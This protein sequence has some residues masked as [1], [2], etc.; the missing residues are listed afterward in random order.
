MQ[1]AINVEHLAYTYPGVDDTPGVAVFKD[2]SLQIE[3]GTFVAVLGGN[4]C[5]KSTLAKHFNAILTP[6]SGTVLVTGID[7]KNEDMLFDIRQTVG[8]VF[9]NPD[10]QIIT[11]TVEEELAFGL[12]NLGVPREQ[13]IR[14]I[15][16]IL[17][18]FNIS[19]LMLLFS[20]T[21]T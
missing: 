9:Q 15:N 13:M 5:G 18:E 12:E 11:S 8:M 21:S 14:D 10:S 16:K 2:L 7:T 4:G 6:D 19:F 1:T 3:Q 17:L 20:E